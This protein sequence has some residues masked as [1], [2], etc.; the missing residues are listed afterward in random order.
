MSEESGAMPEQSADAGGLPRRTVLR[1]GAIGGAGVALA[2]AQGVGAPF[3]AQRGLLSADGA[4][5]ATSM[6]L[7]DGGLFIEKFPTSP[8]ILSPFT[9]PLPVP[10]ALRPVPQSTF[11]AWLEP[12]GPGFGQQSSL[13]NE[14]HQLWPSDIPVTQGGPFPDP[15]VYQIKDQVRT[16]S[17]ST[18]RVLPI[19]ENGRPVVSFDASGA[20]FAAGTRRTLPPSTIYGFNGT[21]PGPMINA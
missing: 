13:R 18:S 12:P 1:L 5:A 17:F 19:D 21:F 9:D 11:T 3:L 6:A 4:F 2:A 10:K 7:A 16:H 20:R 8:L 14:R 15:L